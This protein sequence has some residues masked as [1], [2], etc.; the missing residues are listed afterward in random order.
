MNNVI[1][2]CNTLDLVRINTVIYGRKIRDIPSAGCCQRKLGVSGL[3][4]I[5][6]G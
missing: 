3:G 2:Y 5:F 6:A 1:F 4:D